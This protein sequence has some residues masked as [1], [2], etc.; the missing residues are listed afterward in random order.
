MNVISKY[1]HNHQ[2]DEYVTFWGVRNDVPDILKNMDV[3]MLPSSSEG[4][5]MSIR[6]AERQGLYIVATDTGGIKEMISEDFGTIVERSISAIAETITDIVVNNKITPEV[7][8]ASRNFYLNHF[9]LK[10]NIN[11]FSKLFLSL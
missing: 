7:R 11:T 4:M 1:V 2:L 6:E 5:P 8:E 9:S 10:N 3:F